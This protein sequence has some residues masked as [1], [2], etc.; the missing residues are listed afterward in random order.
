LETSTG[1]QLQNI[2]NTG[3]QIAL[4]FTEHVGYEKPSCTVLCKNMQ[5][6]KGPNKTSGNE[7]RTELVWGGG[8]GGGAEYVQNRNGYNA[9]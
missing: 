9:R 2:Q 1:Q 5:G 4:F 3:Q 6:E 7:H 8:E